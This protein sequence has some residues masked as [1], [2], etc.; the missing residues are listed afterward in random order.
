MRFLRFLRI[1]TEAE[2]LGPSTFLW[3]TALA[4]LQNTRGEKAQAGAPG[5][6][7]VR[8]ERELASIKSLL[9]FSACKRFFAITSIFSFLT[10]RHTVIYPFALLRIGM[11]DIFLY[12]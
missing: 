2:Q 5:E 11:K 10:R 8:K 1:K 6:K 4:S 9:K 12:S 3:S 7:D